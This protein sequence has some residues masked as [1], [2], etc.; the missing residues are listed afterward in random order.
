MYEPCSEFWVCPGV[1]VTCTTCVHIVWTSLNWFTV[2]VGPGL[3][4]LTGPVCG[5]HGQDLDVVRESSGNSLM[6]LKH[7][8]FIK[9]GDMPPYLSDSESLSS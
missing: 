5:S 3:P 7:M 8:L 4:L 9:D 2:R 6:N 1:S